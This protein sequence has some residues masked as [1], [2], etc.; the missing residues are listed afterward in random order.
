MPAD[1][2]RDTFA[3]LR[4]R[5]FLRVLLQ[6]GRPLLDA[7]F[8]EQVANLLH[9]IETLAVDL[10][11]PFGGPENDLGFKLIT[12]NDE[13]LDIAQL[14]SRASEARQK[15]LNDR[16]KQHEFLLGAGH[17]YVD[18]ILCENSEVI[19]YTEQLGHVQLKSNGRYL[20]YLD[21]WERH[22]SQWEDRR[23]DD[24]PRLPS[25]HEVALSRVDT[26]TRTRVEWQVRVVDLKERNLDRAAIKPQRDLWRNLLGELGVALHPGSGRLMARTDPQIPAGA[27][28][29]CL[30][31][32]D[33]GYRGPENLLC[34]V[35]IHAPGEQGKAT[36]KVSFM[37][38]S[39]IFPIRSIQDILITVA[40][41]SCD[42]RSGLT[43]GDWVEVINDTQ[44]LSAEPGVLCKVV[45]VDV[46]TGEVTLNKAPNIAHALSLHPL[47]RRWDTFI[48]SKSK[49]KQTTCEAKV[50]EGDWLNAGYGI[51]LLF[52]KQAQA[53]IYRTGDYW[54][55]P[56]RI[57]TGDIEWPLSN[58]KDSSGHRKPLALLPQGVE[59]HYAPLAL[60][61]LKGDGA[62]DPPTECRSQIEPLMKEL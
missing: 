27:P 5:R 40:Q 22:I 17:Y 24:D 53:D 6:Q 19:G 44:V 51:Q 38:G 34:R 12:E 3:V 41:L 54:L 11:G 33:A 9:Y 48:D 59:H 57:A 2:S 10:I 52:E 28:E 55:I 47:L 46:D 32:P 18:G 26:T 23:L 30:Q 15:E 29:P 31:P 4:D 43:E 16:L 60:I 42:E 37:N 35:E 49:A 13:P 36:Y 14:L 45:H 50:Q 25:I 7:E 39:V 58:E 20:V 62:I 21:V 8:N 56:A 1:I 61:N